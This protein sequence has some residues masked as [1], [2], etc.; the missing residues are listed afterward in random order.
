MANTPPRFYVHTV[1][2][3]PVGRKLRTPHLV[4]D[5]TTGSTVDEYASKRAATMDARERNRTAGPLAPKTT[6]DGI[7]LYPVIH[8]TAGVVYVSVPE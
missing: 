7:T 4:I 5:R 2:P 3:S 6:R 8:P 1:L